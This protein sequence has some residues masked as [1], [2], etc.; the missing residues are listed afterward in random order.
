MN[1][2]FKIF[3]FM[4]YFTLGIWA[5]YLP[6]FLHEKN[7]SSLQI[8]LLLGSM[9][10]AMMVSQ[11]VWGY[12]SDKWGTRRKLLLISNIGAAL[13]GIAL[14]LANS[15]GF[16]F[17]WAIL[18]AS[19]WTPVIP[20][21]T[22]ILLETLEEA[23]QADKF[24]VIRL[25]GS[26]GFAVSSLVI[27]GLFLD[28]IVAYLAWFTGAGFLLLGAISLLLPEKPGGSVVH[29][30]KSRQILAG[31]PR[32][33]IFLIGSIFIGAT[34]GIYNNYQ[35]LFLNFLGAQEWLVGMTVS[36]QAIVEVPF[37]IL[38]PISVKRFGAQAVILAGAVLLPLR[39]ALYYFI[40]RPEWVAPS[41]LI[42][43]VAMVSFFVVGVAYIDQLISPRWRATGQA[44]YGSALF[45]VGSA[46]GNYLTGIALEWFDLRSVWVLSF[47][48]GL[49]GL[50]LLL[51][52]FSRKHPKDVRSPVELATPVE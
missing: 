40:Q 49:I 33:V 31:N 9:P 23:G 11:P 16:A 30:V 52:A 8:G 41:Q 26:I 39:W 13:A 47:I 15:F 29:E 1:L 32:L 42:H 24:S 2:K 21:S 44:L 48:L 51:F 36:L 22:A 14:G 38:V 17:V 5:P 34:L 10:I 7:Y 43:G 46:M 6:V 45:G 19:L 27:G 4:Q 25:W 50:G 12:L 28:Q 3:V 20:I 37:M 35:T 18:F